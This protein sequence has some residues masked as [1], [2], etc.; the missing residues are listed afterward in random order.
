MVPNKLYNCLKFR[1]GKDKRC[2]V[3]LCVGQ[4]CNDIDNE[5]YLNI[6]EVYNN[7]HKLSSKIC[8]LS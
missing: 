4:D 3:C 6:C 1:K 8:G 5:N 2:K 7:V